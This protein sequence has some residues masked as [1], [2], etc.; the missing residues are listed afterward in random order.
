MTGPVLTVTSAVVP[1]ASEAAVVAAYREVTS[2]LPHMVLDTALVRGEGNEFRIVTLW[3]SRE[4]WNE[5]RHEV[6]TSAAVRIF[7]DAG[8]EPTVV[9]YDVVHRAATG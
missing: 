3:R 1:P 8:A 9:A 6:G 4:Q 5:Y 2:A 7:R